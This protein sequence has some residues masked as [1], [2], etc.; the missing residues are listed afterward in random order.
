MAKS[1]VNNVVTISAPRIH[2]AT[3]RLVGTAPFVQARFSAK[4]KQAMMD[5]MAAGS[6]ANGK[7]IREARNFDQDCKD[8]MH[9]G[10]D[11]RSG[12]PA[13][14]FRA[15]MISACRTVGFKMTVAKLS[16]FVA[17]DTF[18][19]VD[20]VPLVH[21]NGTWE[22]L[23]MHTRN[24]TGVADIRVR[25][26]W[27]EWWLDLRVQYDEDQFTLSDVANLLM[28]AGI[29]VGVGEGRPDSKS[30]TGLGF[31]TFRIEGAE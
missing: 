1:P 5:K 6:T 19:A 30:S 29:Q 31:G 24:Q 18:D 3:F 21:L 27:R 25:P 9:I 15:A 4:A 23:D 22:R 17:A 7:K 8:A 2:T 11:G 16:I 10:I 20:G 12:I 26:M 14:A 13:G 28:R